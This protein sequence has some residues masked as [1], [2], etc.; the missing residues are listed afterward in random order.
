MDD[1]K[2]SVVS[3]RLDPPSVLQH[4]SALRV[5]SLPFNAPDLIS[6]WIMGYDP[7]EDML[8]VGGF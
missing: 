5:F 6:T 4:C 1:P 7:P 2:G 8:I 3:A